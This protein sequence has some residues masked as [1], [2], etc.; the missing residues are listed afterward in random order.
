MHL[1]IASTNPV[2]IQSALHGFRQMFPDVTFTAEGISVPS[3]V[4]DQPMTDE[5]T[6][7]GALN[8][9]SNARAAHPGSDYWVGIEGG[10][11]EKH[12]ELWTFAWVVVLGLSSPRHEGYQQSEPANVADVGLGGEVIL[13]GKARTGAFMLPQEVASLVRSGVEL[14]IADDRVFGRSNSKQT[15]GAVGLLTA[16]LI[17]RQRYYEHA[18][19]LALIPFKN[20]SFSWK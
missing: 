16:D 9:A 7:Q 5:E 10:C 3:G 1:T 13:T 11:E 14:G 18:V 2:K 12:G 8:R 4:S 20:I 6:L 17:D 19:V 15:N